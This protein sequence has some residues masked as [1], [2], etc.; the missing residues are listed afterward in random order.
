MYLNQN[1]NQRQM[2]V[3][4]SHCV[5]TVPLPVLLL[6]G[7]ETSQVNL[8]AKACVGVQG[9]QERPY[10]GVIKKVRATAQWVDAC[11]C[12]NAIADSARTH[13]GP[14]GQQGVLECGLFGCSAAIMAELELED[15]KDMVCNQLH[16]THPCLQ[17]PSSPHF[18]PLC[19]HAPFCLPL[20]LFS[21]RAPAHTHTRRAHC[22]LYPAT[23]LPS[24]RSFHT[25]VA[26]RSTAPTQC[27]PWLLMKTC[28][29]PG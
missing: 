20:D 24:H 19:K 3:T 26:S 17:P 15:I 4:F 22:P 16:D 25:P 2:S 6:S 29:C 27:M 18:H 11:C 23:P 8:L 28:C 9:R 12:S 5:S 21:T 7:L 1:Q 10:Y 14:T 13:R